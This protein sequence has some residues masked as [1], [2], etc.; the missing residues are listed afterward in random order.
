[1]IF[2]KDC[3]AFNILDVLELNQ[4]DVS[5]GNSGR[6]FDALSFRIDSD[7]VIKTKC[8]TIKLKSNSVSYFPSRVDYT[9]TA[10]KDRMIVIHFNSL[11]YISKK[12]EYFYP[13]NSEKIAELFKEILMVWQEKEI[14]YLYICS[15][16]LYRIFAEIYKEK[17]ITS[18][19]NSKIKNSIKYIS[20]FFI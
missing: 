9:R 3:I 6:N 14:G 15:G 1:M 13:E 18:D 20:E 4:T 16:I 11:N 5:I 12:I 7:T 17:H 8:E 19:Y 2:E 10:K